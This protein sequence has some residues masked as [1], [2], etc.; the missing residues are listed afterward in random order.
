MPGPSAGRGSGQV[1]DDPRK[2]R[3]TQRE[4]SNGDYQKMD[5]Q[6][7]DDDSRVTQPETHRDAHELAPGRSFIRPARSGRDPFPIFWTCAAPKFPGIRKG[8]GKFAGVGKSVPYPLWR[9]CSATLSSP[10][11]PPPW[12]GTPQPR[13]AAAFVSRPSFDEEWIIWDLLFEPRLRTPSHGSGSERARER[14]SRRWA[15]TSASV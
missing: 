4:E 2:R 12:R 14:A 6:P 13:E 15:I 1:A 3:R 9:S 7:G 11:R 10:R 5:R 8:P